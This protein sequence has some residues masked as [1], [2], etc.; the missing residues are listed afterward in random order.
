MFGIVCILYRTYSV[1]IQ[2]FIITLISIFNQL[3]E[4]ELIA[5]RMSF[6]LR[7]KNKNEQRLFV[8]ISNYFSFSDSF[9]CRFWFLSSFSLNFWL[10]TYFENRLEL[11]ALGGVKRESDNFKYQ[12]TAN[13]STKAPGWHAYRIFCVN[14]IF[15][16]I[17]NKFH[18]TFKGVAIESV[19]IWRWGVFMW[20]RTFI[21]DKRPK[22][23]R[24]TFFLLYN[25]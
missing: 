16:E 13:A 9:R 20:V 6:K 10:N 3:N 8:D 23:M 24:E 19:T 11:C 18:A 25:I 14:S 2:S 22:N 15:N 4:R 17:H 5:I 7:N 12:I 1:F 21:S